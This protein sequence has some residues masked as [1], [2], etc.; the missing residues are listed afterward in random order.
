MNQSY[1]H[2]GSAG[3]ALYH[4]QP[5]KQLGGGNFYIY[6]A[7][8]PD[9]RMLRSHAESVL[10]LIRN[11]PYITAAA[12]R[13]DVE[14]LDL[15]GWRENYKNNT[16]LTDMCCT[17]L[18]LPHPPRCEPWLQV[19]DIKRVA[20]VVINRCPRWRNDKFPWL[21]AYMMYGKEAVFV[22]RP[23][24]HSEF[25]FSWGP[26]SYHYTENHL[27][28]AKVIAG[29]DLFIGNQ[30]SAAA[31]AE[32]MKVAMVQETLN[33]DHWWSNCHWDR[34]HKVH[35]YDKDA[36]MPDPDE[37]LDYWAGAK[38]EIVQSF[39]GIQRDQLK[40]LACEIRRVE[41]IS[42][43]MAEI[44]IETRGSTKLMATVCPGKTL[45]VIGTA[46]TILD[47]HNVT[48]H[49]NAD[50]LH[51]QSESLNFVHLHLSEIA[52]YDDVLYTIER[53]WNKMSHD[54]SII[55]SGDSDLLSRCELLPSGLKRIRKC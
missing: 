6:P 30:S 50:M 54:G 35:V 28:L 21:R 9:H 23:E 53:L 17:W 49:A 33:R 24:E 29:A 37:L 52:M 45:H 20:K 32:G 19:P 14:G 16:N 3:D 4:L 27:E 40:S 44:G 34:K 51:C 25:C 2:N 5:V 46:D 41:H 13:E 18:G 22:G 39:T 1:S 11:Q 47:G 8:K 12:W 31:V 10:A 43:D 7:A 38:A 48:W 36:V 42:G 55:I 15:S 26:I